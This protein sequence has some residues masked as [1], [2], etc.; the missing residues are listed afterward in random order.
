MEVV[1]VG[2]IFGPE[3]TTDWIASA[4]DLAVNVNFKVSKVSQRLW[5]YLFDENNRA[6]SFSS[7]MQN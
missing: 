7:R 2:G 6:F 3:F 4:R 1:D 5:H